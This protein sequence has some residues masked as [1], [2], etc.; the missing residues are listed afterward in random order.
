MQEQGFPVW[1]FVAFIVGFPLFWIA[2]VYAVAFFSGWSAL[3]QRFPATSPATGQTFG[4]T[5]A[6]LSMF[7]N[8]NRCLKVTVSARGIDVVPQIFFRIGHDP[9]F[10]PWSKVVGRQRRR[11]IF[12]TSVVIALAEPIDRVITF[13]GKGLAD[14]IDEYAPTPPAATAA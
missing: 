14:A 13:Y 9:I 10:I 4:W 1:A 2:V 11:M 3:A 5:S 6:K 12:A 7:S 8:Y